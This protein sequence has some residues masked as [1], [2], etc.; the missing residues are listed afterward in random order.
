M[1]EKRTL[2]DYKRPVITVSK[3]DMLASSIFEG[4][5]SPSKITMIFTAIK[6]VIA[7]AYIIV[8]YKLIKSELEIVS[9]TV[10]NDH[11]EDNSGET[12]TNID[13]LL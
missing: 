4:S 5:K 1:T 8:R 10:R 2:A 7:L 12:N 11:I 3:L 6:L 9:Q 13:N